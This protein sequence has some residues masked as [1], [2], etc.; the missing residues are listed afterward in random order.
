MLDP[1][2]DHNTHGEYISNG[3]AGVPPYSIAK[4]LLMG[5]ISRVHPWWPFLRLPY[6]RSCFKRMYQNARECEDYEKF[7]F[8][9]ILA[10][11]S[12]E[13]CQS[14]EYSR[15]LDLNKPENYFQTALHF[16][17]RFRED[18]RDLQGLQAVT[19]LT[20]WMLNSSSR[21]HSNDL[22]HLTRYTMSVALEIG[23]H[24]HNPS[25]KFSS[26]ELELR[27]R[28]WWAIYSLERSVLGSRMTYSRIS[29]KQV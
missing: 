22:W 23:L 14:N 21:K 5:Y 27:T 13:V 18:R 16:F 15:M 1:S 4:L 9:M 12:A 17:E 29:A 20:I 3:N 7:I 19:L 8:F 10:L 2:F 26:E 6:I 11:G 25:W 28:T 24:R